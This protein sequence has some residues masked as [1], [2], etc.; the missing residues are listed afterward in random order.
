ML[1]IV[2]P[3]GYS[4]YPLSMFESRQSPTP[5]DPPPS[6]LLVLAAEL[7]ELTRSMIEIESPFGEGELTGGRHLIPFQRS[8]EMFKYML[9][10]DCS[11]VP[12]IDHLPRCRSACSWIGNY[13]TPAESLAELAQYAV[14]LYRLEVPRLNP[15]G[16]MVLDHL[17]G[18][19][20]ERS[21]HDDEAMP[22]AEVILHATPELTDL[23][24][25][26]AAAASQPLMERVPLDLSQ[27][28]HFAV[29]QAIVSFMNS[30]STL[31]A[32]HDTDG[33]DTW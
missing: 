29:T 20:V 17:F 3:F 27:R 2:P 15:W 6:P 23:L 18:V 13:G 25:E 24:V 32:L 31:R 28:V 9:D 7:H 10:I 5:D 8:V 16:T 21:R 12:N 4:R 19:I 30:V 26:E 11:P 33:G 1:F 22:A 14:A